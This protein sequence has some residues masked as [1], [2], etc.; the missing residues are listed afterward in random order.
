M[1]QPKWVLAMGLCASTGGMFNNYAV[2]QG[3]DH[4]VP[5]DMYLAGCPPRPEMLLDSIIK[6]H[7]KIQDRQARGQQD[8]ADTEREH[9]ALHLPIQPSAPMP[10]R[11]EHPAGR[12]RG[13]G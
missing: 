6:L 8:T 3:V 5:V 11:D 10:A 4:I 2:V 9:I 7:E 13:T 12:T 1:P